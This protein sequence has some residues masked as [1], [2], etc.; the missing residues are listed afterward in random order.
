M[1]KYLRKTEFWSKSNKNYNKRSFAGLIY[2]CS[3]NIHEIHS[4]WKRRRKAHVKLDKKEKIFFLNDSNALALCY[5]TYWQIFKLLWNL[6]FSH[7]PINVLVCVAVRKQ[8]WWKTFQVSYLGWGK[9]SMCYCK[10]MVK[11]GYSEKYSTVR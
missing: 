7:F 9:G 10:K 8:F 6:K 11:V 2:C 3:P 4:T 5:T 1:I